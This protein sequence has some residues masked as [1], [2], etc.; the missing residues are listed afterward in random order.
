MWYMKKQKQNISLNQLAMTDTSPP[1]ASFLFN[2]SGNQSLDH[3]QHLI[4][5][6]S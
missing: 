5:I 4:F 2:L 1:S 3:F 6:A